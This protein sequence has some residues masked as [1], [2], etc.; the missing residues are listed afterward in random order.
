MLPTPTYE[1]VLRDERSKKEIKTTEYKS[2][3]TVSASPL[4][5]ISNFGFKI[6]MKSIDLFLMYYLII[7]FKEILFV[8]AKKQL[9][10][11]RE[12]KDIKIILVLN[13]FLN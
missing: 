5:K 4:N 1:N 7:N 13:Y 6:K 10:K 3:W 8:L 12:N 11:K 2:K 9:Y